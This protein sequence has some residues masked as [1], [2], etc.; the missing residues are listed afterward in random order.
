[1]IG[2]ETAK[3]LER[4]NFD[5][6]TEPTLEL[7]RILQKKHLLRVPFENLDIHYKTPIKLNNANNFEK[8]V[9]FCFLFRPTLIPAN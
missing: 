2:A 1:M 7:L 5:G 3:Y 9:T 8:A 4:I 6:A